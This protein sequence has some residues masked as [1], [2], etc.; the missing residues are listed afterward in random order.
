MWRRTEPRPWW[1][2]AAGAV[3]LAA[4]AVQAF[5]RGV[6]VPLLGWIDLAI[7][8]AGHVL[9]MMLLDVPNAMMGNGFQTLVPLALAAV[10]AVRER[11]LLGAVLCLGWA[12]TTLQDASVYIADAPHQRL[13]LIGG[14][15]DWAFAL[16]ELDV[17]ASADTIARVVWTAGLVVMIVALFG[18][19][20]ARWWE[21]AL[22]GAPATPSVTPAPPVPPAPQPAVWPSSDDPGEY[23]A[24]GPR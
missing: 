3:V 13:Q 17:L 12:A 4:M 6:R 7:H 2:H 11:D 22:L 15:H 19:V 9:M 14:Y 10:F 8:E 23:F 1:Q 16:A 21:P 24:S 20:G 5:G 18:T